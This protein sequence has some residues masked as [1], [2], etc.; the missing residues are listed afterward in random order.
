MDKAQ[1]QNGSALVYILIAIA[2]LAALT[3]TFMDSSG[4]QTSSQNTFNTVSALKS[5][6]S[7]ISS[8]VQECVLTYPQGDAGADG[9]SGLRN[10]VTANY[11]YPINPSSGYFTAPATPA[12]DDA[13]ANI[14]CP[15]NPGN[16]TEHAPIFG[17]TS[18]KFMPPAPNLFENWTYYSGPDGVFFFIS[19]DKTDP[20]LASALEKLDDQFS[21]CEADVV[22]NA[23]GSGAMDLTTEAASGPSCPAFSRCL[24]VWMIAADPQYVGD[25]A[26]DESACP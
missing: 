2:L 3:S 26:T 18:G 4:Q 6:I 20:Y 25:T 16:S 1:N 24:R 17:G 21:E 12:A 11:A 22:D 10:P 8:S 15:G 7:L 14:R 5:Q 9:N 23:G 13:V 19:T